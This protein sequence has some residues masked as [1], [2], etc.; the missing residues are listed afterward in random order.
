MLVLL[1]SPPDDAGVDVRVRTNVRAYL[2]AGCGLWLPVGEWRNTVTT[3]GLTRLAQWWGGSSNTAGNP[4]VLA[5]PGYVAL[6]TGTGTPSTADQFMFAE[7]DGTRAALTYTL[8]LTTTTELVA[9]SYTTTQA[10]GT[11]TEVGLWDSD[12]G[13]ATVGTGGVSSGT[14]TLPL[15]ASAPAVT[16]GSTPG[17]YTTA[18][19]SDGTN[20][21]YISIA[22]SAAADAS[23]WTLQANLQYAHAAATPIVVFNGT[24]W[25]H[26]SLSPS[27]V[28]PN[29]QSLLLQWSATFAAA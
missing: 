24:L 10:N 17:L 23:S 8:L 19:V 21:E 20:S 27:L 7:T 14:T 1:G 18:Y 12:V 25:A 2:R 9:T 5:P 4:G 6:G 28:K 22:T 13:S 26:A 16:G 11:W 3:L 15:G 29:G